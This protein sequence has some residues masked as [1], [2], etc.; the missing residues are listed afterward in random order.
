M[1]LNIY[2]INPCFLFILLDLN[3]KQIAISNSKDLVSQYYIK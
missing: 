3:E 1:L 2:N